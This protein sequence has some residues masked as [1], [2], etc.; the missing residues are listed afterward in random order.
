MGL[1]LTTQEFIDKAREVHG[2]IYDYSKSI[3]LHSG[4]K[5]IIICKIHGEFLQT[6][7]AHLQGRGCRQCGLINMS[8][9]SRS[10]L[11]IFISRSS[12]IHNNKYDY[13]K[14]IYSNNQTK[15]VIIC[16]EH[17]EFE[18]SPNSHLSGRGCAECSSCLIKT[19]E[20]F[21]EEANNIHNNKYN[22]S[23]AIYINIKT[24][25]I[26]ICVI[27]GEFEQRPDQHLEGSGCFKCY[28]NALKTND[29]F[30]KE[31]AA[32]HNNK[33]DY[34]KSN[35]IN[36]STKLIII[37]PNHGEFDQTPNAHLL[38]KGCPNCYSN[39]SKLEI[40]WLDD[41]KIPKEYRQKIIYINNKIYKV[42]AYDPNINT[43]YEFN[44]D[45]WH[46]NPKFYDKDKIHP[47]S[48][49]TYG[50]LHSATIKKELE[51]M[52]AG[53]NVISIWESDFKKGNK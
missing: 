26:V 36:N 9:R 44:G 29:N 51:L 20:R 11:N 30:I 18:Q 17:G 45:Y 38:G 5:I 21:I 39:I 3:Y 43:I 50:E 48:K 31:A 42:D 27:H 46:G 37:C 19:T 22:Y 8:N 6:P 13:S 4:K 34:S 15:L 35:Y 33:Y 52:G 49:K 25:L 2:E 7:N 16:K 24:K 40:L 32:L 47:V 28:G 1:K 10:T 23:K 53:Y 41:L 12:K 14:S